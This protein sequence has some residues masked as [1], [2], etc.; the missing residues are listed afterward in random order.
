MIAVLSLA[1]SEF[2]FEETRNYVMQRKAFGKTIAD[3]QVHF[4]VCSL[5]LFFFFCLLMFCLLMF[6]CFCALLSVCFSWSG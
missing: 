4:V 6:V 1:G 3:L 5:L 2:I